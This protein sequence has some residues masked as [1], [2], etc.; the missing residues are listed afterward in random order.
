M[1]AFLAALLSLV[2]KAVS[3]AQAQSTEKLIFE[4]PPYLIAAKAIS[5]GDTATLERLIAEGLDVNYEGRETGAPW[6]NDTVTLLLWAVLKGQLECTE[7][8]LKAGANPDKASAGGLTPLM[9]TMMAEMPERTSDRMF[10]LLLVRYKAN[11]N[12]IFTVGLRKSALVIA[13][14][15]RELG[16]KRFERAEMLLK[17]GADI[18]LDLD[19]GETAVIFLTLGHWRAVLWLLEH[20]A[21][22]EARD[23]LKSTMMG[24]LRMSYK[25]H[26]NLTP[27]N[28]LDR[29]K[30]RDWLL[31]H[32][33]DR[34]RFDPAI[35]PE[36]DY[37]D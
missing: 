3:M 22:P 24:Y 34:S 28:Q 7:L 13:L 30:V 27:E 36:P 9:M 15:D 18:N 25:D 20:G 17:Y 29:D 1:R 35:H 19:R 5:A 32:G 8:L 4:K 14:E 31:A 37:R 6:G 11:P 2:M 21:N 23:F 16:E 33:I 12:V 26:P 10:E